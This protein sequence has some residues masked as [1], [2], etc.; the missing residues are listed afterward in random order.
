MQRKLKHSFSPSPSVSIGS[1]SLSKSYVSETILLCFLILMGI[2]GFLC[3]HES[4]GLT[5]IDIK[6]GSQSHLKYSSVSSM[7]CQ[8][9]GNLMTLHQVIQ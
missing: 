6:D 8:P 1:R 7:A 4:A 3:I 5:H 9:Y 2:L